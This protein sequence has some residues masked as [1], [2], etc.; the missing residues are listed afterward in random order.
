MSKEMSARATRTATRRCSGRREHIARQ[1]DGRGCERQTAARA[2]RACAIDGSVH[3]PRACEGR[4][5]TR[6]RGSAGWRNGVVW[7]V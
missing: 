7:V 3:E 4:G 5:E 1:V 6:A 2:A